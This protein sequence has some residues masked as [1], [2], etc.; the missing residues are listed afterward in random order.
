MCFILLI[1][2][3]NKN[4][5]LE[6]CWENMLFTIKKKSLN[7]IPHVF[8]LQLL[9]FYV[10]YNHCFLSGTV[11]IYYRKNLKNN[12][13]T[14]CP[15]FSLIDKYSIFCS[16]TNSSIYEFGLTFAHCF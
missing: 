4:L 11:E 6:I 14:F 13:T 9:F 5:I 12:K 16:M 15:C 2:I 3:S 8:V 7:N 1:K 10:F